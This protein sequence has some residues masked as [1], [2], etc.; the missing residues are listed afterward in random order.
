[1]ACSPT[2][3]RQAQLILACQRD[4]SK[5]LGTDRQSENK[6]VQLGA[7]ALLTASAIQAA[8]NRNGD[9]VTGLDQLHPCRPA[10]QRMEF[11]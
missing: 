6:E 8:A 9:E 10:S 4:I 1:M 5:G 2:H 3:Q 11:E 7:Q